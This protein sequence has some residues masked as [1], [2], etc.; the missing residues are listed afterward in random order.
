MGVTWKPSSCSFG[1]F[2]QKMGYTDVG[3]FSNSVLVSALLVAKVTI[4][5][6]FSFPVHSYRQ[7]FLLSSCGGLLTLTKLHILAE[8]AALLVFQLCSIWGHCWTPSL[9]TALS[10]FLG[11]L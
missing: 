9:E 8:S 7:M 10:K 2:F 11:I 6:T 3:V 1:F 4:A 5:D